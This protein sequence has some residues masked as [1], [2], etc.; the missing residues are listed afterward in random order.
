MSEVGI[1]LA[2]NA[3]SAA[4]AG[5][6]VYRDNTNEFM[7]LINIGDYNTGQGAS[8]DPNGNLY[9]N[10]AASTTIAL[11]GTPGVLVVNTPTVTVSGTPNVSI[12]N[13]PE[14]IVGNTPDVIVS[15]VP[16]VSVSG[17][18][19][20][21]I[22]NVPSVVVTNNPSVSVTNTP[23]VTI[24]GTPNVS[25]TNIPSVTISGT[26]PVSLANLVSKNVQA[27][28][29]LGVQNAKDS[30]RN[31]ILFQGGNL[32]PT[33]GADIVASFS[34]TKN[35]ASTG[36]S[37]NYYTIT[38][39]KTLRISHIGLSALASSNILCFFTFRVNSGGGTITTTN[40]I[41]Y[42]TAFMAGTNLPSNSEISFPDGIEFYGGSVG[43]SY[44]SAASA[45][46][47]YILGF[48]Y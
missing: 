44:N 2:T 28:T 36:A 1:N 42:Q 22:T 29:L 47:V 48:E 45:S 34:I 38:P 40:P 11:S 39:G 33:N 3:A 43:F 37:S 19:S 7:Q 35:S 26:P 12:V 8:V 4:I 15:N 17:I 6:T 20:T 14:V 41:F 31:L 27:P 10:V 24:V 5:N 9:V 23:D 32:A 30:G 13:M 18:I 46:F 25:V 21:A 16:T